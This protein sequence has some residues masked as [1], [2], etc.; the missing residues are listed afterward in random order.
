MLN[1]H[2]PKYGYFPNPTKTI[3]L[4]KNPEVAQQ[5]RALFHRS[6]V[7]IIMEGH[8]YLGAALGGSNFKSNYVKEKVDK[9][10]EDLEELAKLAV[11]EPQIALSAYTKGLCH[12]WA[13]IQRTIPGISTLFLPLEHCIRETFIPA[14]IGRKVS[15][16]ERRIIS[17]PVRYGG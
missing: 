1:L 2:G 3:L 17:L 11:D 16:I 4:I 12:R 7:Q 15:D 9:W 5:A 8:R 6:G 13:F 14:I 10:I